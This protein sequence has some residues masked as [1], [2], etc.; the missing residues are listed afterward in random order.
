MALKPYWPRAPSGPGT[1][2]TSVWGLHKPL[3]NRLTGKHRKLGSALR[4]T[5][6]PTTGPGTACTQVVLRTQH[7]LVWVSAPPFVLMVFVHMDRRYHAVH[8]KLSVVY[9]CT[10]QRTQ[11]WTEPIKVKSRQLSRG[12]WTPPRGPQQK[13]RPR[14]YG[15]WKCDV[16]NRTTSVAYGKLCYAGQIPFVLFTKVELSNTASSL[17]GRIVW[18]E[19]I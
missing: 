4:G 15:H 6:V 11:L 10:R 2:M 3:E 7:S 19:I 1:C 5:W 17:P 13:P 8:R 12:R 18:I 9:L 14:V 16:V